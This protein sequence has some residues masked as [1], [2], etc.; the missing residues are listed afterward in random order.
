MWSEAA[1]AWLA[2]QESRATPWLALLCGL[3]L[4]EVGPWWSSTPDSVLYLS[5]ARSL[6]RSGELTSL[7][8]THTGL[9]PGY[10]VLLAPA[11]WLSDRPFWVIAIVQWLLGV[12]VI[13]LLH[14]W[15]RRVTPG[16]ALLTTGLVAVNVSFWMLVRRPLSEICFLVLLLASANSMDAVLEASR[17]KTLALRGIIACGLLAAAVLVREAAIVLIGGFAV[18]AVLARRSGDRSRFA[19]LVVALTAGLG[20]ACLVA[21]VGYDLSTLAANGA[22]RVVGSH[23]DGF[24]DPRSTFAEKLGEGFRLRVAEIGRLVVPGMFKA[25]GPPGI[26]LDANMAIEGAC[27]LVVLAGWLRLVRT[28]RAVLVLALPFY[29]ALHSAWAFDAGTRYMLP[30]LPVIV[31]SL[32]ALVERRSDRLRIAALAVVAHLG[33]TLGYHLSRELPRAHECHRLWPTVDRVAAGTG[34]ADGEIAAL[35]VPEC[36]ALMLSFTL[37]R[38][39]ARDPTTVAAIA[40]LVTGSPVDAPSGFRLR[41]EVDSLKLWQREAHAVAASSFENATDRN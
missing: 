18:A 29:F 30:M 34:P 3:L 33:V 41:D 38:P 1:E 17:P 24:L 9:P 40:W 22:Q 4:L 35:S 15:A 11:F 8:S 37:D 36:A 14:A 20:I 31:A 2:R 23:L 26:W 32:A 6:A 27:A 10:A 25:Y 7:G 5:M 28:T 13:F 16:R 12:A 21:F 19:G 39:V